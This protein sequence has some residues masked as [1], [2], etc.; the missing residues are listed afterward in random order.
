MKADEG[1]EKVAVPRGVK[2]EWWDGAFYPYEQV[3]DERTRWAFYEAHEAAN[4]TLY[5]WPEELGRSLWDDPNMPMIVSAAMDRVESILYRDTR[6]A[7]RAPGVLMRRF[8]V[9]EAYP[10]PEGEDPFLIAEMRPKWPIATNLQNWTKKSSI[11]QHRHGL[12]PEQ[13]PG[14]SE[15]ERDPGAFPDTPEGRRSR[16]EHTHRRKQITAEAVRKGVTP[17]EYSEL[18]KLD[19]WNV[20]RGA[21]HPSGNDPEELHVHVSVAKYVFPATP[22]AR[23]QTIGTPHAH[24]GYDNT[25]RYGEFGKLYEWLHVIGK[26]HISWRPDPDAGPYLGLLD[27]PWDD[28][29][30]VPSVGLGG[31]VAKVERAEEH[32]HEED[33]ADPLKHPAKR[34]SWHPYQHP[35]R[36]RRDRVFMAMEGCLKEAAIASAGEATFSCPSI[37]LWDTYELKAFAQTHLADEPR[38]GYVPHS[39]QPPGQ[40]RIVHRPQRKTVFVVCDSDWEPGVGTRPADDDAVIMQ[41]LLLRD[42]LRLYLGHD[43]VHACAPAAPR[44]IDGTQIC[45]NPKHEKHGVDD[46]L[47]PC[48]EGRVDDLIVM[49]RDVPGAQ[50]QDAFLERYGEQRDEMGRRRRRPVMVKDMIVL[51]Y[52]ATLAAKNGETK[53]SLRAVAKNLQQEL[54]SPTVDAARQFV[55]ASVKRLVEFGYVDEIEEIKRRKS[56]QKLR[57]DFEEWTGALRVREPFQAEV[58]LSTVRNKS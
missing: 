51:R 13:Y 57:K 38:Q 36:W 46:F 23:Q 29:Y 44:R 33:T 31:E 8:E 53:V 21:S 3:V 9:P 58:F 30:P 55:E 52:L 2:R 32:A 10:V 42:R 54:G 19:G 50:W 35:E 11:R 1:F 18:E 7:T 24:T 14:Q 47:G 6:L 48:T 40:A 39:E 16:R 45:K 49:H 26:N 22:L 12:A 34:L 41:A 17:E 27:L 43:R 5:A 15:I 4:P 20:M 56:G 37:T 28:T 25:E